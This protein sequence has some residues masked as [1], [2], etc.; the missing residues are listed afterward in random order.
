MADKKLLEEIHY[1][2]VMDTEITFDQFK[3]YVLKENTTVTEEPKVVLEE[4]KDKVLQYCHKNPKLIKQ[5]QCS[6]GGIYKL[7]DKI[8][9]FNGSKNPVFRNK[10]YFII[11]SFR[12]S[13]DKSKIC[14]VFNSN[15]PNGIGLDKIELY[16]EPKVKQELS[17]LEQAKLK[18]P[19]GTKVKSLFY[20]S[21]QGNIININFKHCGIWADLN[22]GK[23]IFL[24]SRKNNKWAEIIED[25]KLPEKWC[26]Q[27][28]S[29][30]ENFIN[31]VRD[32][33]CS[34]TFMTSSLILP[35]VKNSWYCDSDA[36]KRGF[37]EITFEQFKKYVLKDE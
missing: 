9:V 36:K 31:S 30:N 21:V 28:N 18:Y 8:R 37:T 12:W 2:D 23:G 15:F 35:N 5:V 6:E 16:V 32:R 20:N 19:I 25:F 10:K 26:V 13:N 3:K 33:S 22:T 1:L 11:Q 27:V 29:E 17:L 7:G 4:P 14:A 34:V 24:Y